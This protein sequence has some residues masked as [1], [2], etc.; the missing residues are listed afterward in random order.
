MTVG[1]FLATFCY[2]ECM[3]VGIDIGGTLRNTRPST[4]DVAEFLTGPPN[5][6]A[7]DAASWIISKVN[8]DN[9]YIICRCSKE[10][11][12]AVET[13]LEVYGFINAGLKRE[14]VYF[15]RQW[16]EKTHLAKRL[17]LDVFIDDVIDVLDP[18][19]HIVT[20][21]M[22]FSEDGT[23]D[24]PSDGT[25]IKLNGWQEVKQYLNSHVL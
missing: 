15:C 3:K 19:Q 24:Q 11:E 4:D 21:R 2:D 23:L 16:S 8:R 20:H 7:L 12:V 13:W 9:V 1:A 18:M 10:S 17:G 6:G 14:N 25:I 5:I 22:L